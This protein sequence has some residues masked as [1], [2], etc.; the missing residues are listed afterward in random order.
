MP[1][2]F[3][4]KLQAKKETMEQVFSCEFCEIFKNSF[5][6]KFPVAAAKQSDNERSDNVLQ[7][8]KECYEEMNPPFQDENINQIHRIRKTYTDKNTEKKSNPSSQSLNLE[9]LVNIFIMQDQSILPK[10]NGNQVVSAD[11]TSS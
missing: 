3:L 2:S 11:L 7:R 9:N 10:A 5:H 1:E 8:V 4:I 6:R